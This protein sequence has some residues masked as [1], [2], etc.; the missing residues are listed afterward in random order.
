MPG[1][2]G[3]RSWVTIRSHERLARDIRPRRIG[4]EKEKKKKNTNIVIR[5]ETRYSQLRNMA[6]MDARVE[7]L[8]FYSIGDRGKSNENRIR[9]KSRAWPRENIFY[10][11]HAFRSVSLKL[12]KRIRLVEAWTRLPQCYATAT[13]YARAWRQKEI[14]ET[15]PLTH[16]CV[17]TTT[18]QYLRMHGN[19][20]VT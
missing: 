11:W 13:N 10:A 8:S 15:S 9:G 2:S 3:A 5:E 18:T 6:V 7:R 20:V 19:D 16:R 4:D 14:H 17:W 12:F 1:Q